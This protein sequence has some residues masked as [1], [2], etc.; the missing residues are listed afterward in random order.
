MRVYLLGS[1]GQSNTNGNALI[2]VELLKGHTDM[3]G[4]TKYYGKHIVSPF[5]RKLK[6][7]AGHV[8]RITDL[9]EEYDFSTGS[10]GTFNIAVGK[11]FYVDTD[12]MSEYLTAYPYKI[13]VLEQSG[14][15]S[16][17]YNGTLYTHHESGNLKTKS[18]YKKGR[19]HS[20][21]YYRDDPYNSL[22]KVM[23][24]NEDNKL[25]CEFLYDGRESLIKQMWYNSRGKIFH[26]VNHASEPE[27]EP[28][29]VPEPTLSADTCASETT[30]ETETE[31]DSEN[32]ADADADQG[33]GPDPGLGTNNGL[34]TKP[35]DED[36]DD[37][38]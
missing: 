11:Y 1:H 18:N 21:F 8:T 38:L 7:N 19:L 31:T 23:Q 16:R 34:R 28:V 24:Y 30:T 5:Y 4:I 15:V 13:G 3:K 14:Y 10:I 17:G 27:P 35:K 20:R 32:D 6:L 9:E 29:P 37:D 33:S 36:E 22:E 26:K 12:K 25:D 2:T